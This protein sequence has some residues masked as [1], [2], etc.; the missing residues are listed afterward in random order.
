M[1]IPILPDTMEAWEQVLSSWDAWLLTFV[2]VAV[3]PVVGYLRFRRLTQGG[4]IVSQH[5]KLIAYARTICLQWALVGALLVVL[6]RHGLSAADDGERIGDT[7][8]TFWTTAAVLATT[9]GLAPFVWLRVRRSPLERLGR[10]VWHLRSF[11][12]A[13]GTEMVVFMAVSLTA[14]TCEELLWRGWLINVLGVATGSV[15]LGVAFSAAVFGIGHAYQG[16]KGMLRTGLIGLQLA[17]LFVFVGS[18][19]PGQV[20]HAA[21][22]LVACFA[23]ATAVSR[24][25]AA[26]SARIVEHE[27]TAGSAGES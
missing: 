25:N 19:I 12:P 5:A 17:L 3:V 7:D 11:V 16:W 20:L 13:F 2:L 14:G 10:S 4:R 22:D 21:V 23:S 1:P 27:P 9:A 24:L 18:L 6:K 15:W 8:Q 26:E